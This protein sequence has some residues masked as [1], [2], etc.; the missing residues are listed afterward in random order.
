MKFLFSAFGFNFL[1]NRIQFR[2]SFSIHIRMIL[3]MFSANRFSAS[4]FRLR[5]LFS[6][7]QFLVHLYSSVQP[8][9][10]LPVFYLGVLC[11]IEILLAQLGVCKNFFFI[12][13][14]EFCWVQQSTLAIVVFQTWCILLP[15]LPPLKIFTQK[16]PPPHI[17]LVFFLFQLSILSFSSAIQYFNFFYGNIFSEIICLQFC[18]L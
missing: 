12:Y 15:V 18:V 4:G 2:K 14:K 7:L 1:G 3:F 13:N 5:P 6:I 17:W 8:E 11:W 10:L 9:G 16:I